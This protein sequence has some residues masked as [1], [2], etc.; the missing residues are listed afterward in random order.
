MFPKYSF[1]NSF[2]EVFA[3]NCLITVYSRARQLFLLWS[4]AKFKIVA[5][6]MVSVV[7]EVF[8]ALWST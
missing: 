3:F 7:K 8:W 5:S 6:E 1:S 2:E 4:P